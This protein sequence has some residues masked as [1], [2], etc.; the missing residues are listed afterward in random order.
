PA[1]AKNSA[2]TTPAVEKTTPKKTRAKKPLSNDRAQKR[3]KTKEPENELDENQEPKELKNFEVKVTVKAKK[4]PA[5]PL[6]RTSRRTAK[7]PDLEVRKNDEEDLKKNT[8][9]KASR[10]NKR[11][12]LIQS[13]DTQDKA[14]K[15]GSQPNR[16]KRQKKSKDPINPDPKSLGY[17][18]HDRKS[19]LTDDKIE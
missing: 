1:K 12:A 3:R 15:E 7:K 19:F 8:T 18:L 5:A 10:I 6:R 11:K 9:P 13:S 14:E 4:P 2:N 17:L 16:S